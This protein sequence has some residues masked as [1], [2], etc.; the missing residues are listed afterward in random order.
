MGGCGARPSRGEDQRQT[1][2]R[3]HQGSGAWGRPPAT[4]PDCTGGGSQALRPGA[5]V[6]TA[7]NGSPSR[8]PRGKGRPPGPPGLQRATHLP[9]GSNPARESPRLHPSLRAHH[10][11]LNTS[12]D[13]TLTPAPGSPSPLHMGTTLLIPTAP[14]ANRAQGFRPQCCCLPV[15]LPWVKEP[16]QASL[17]SSIKWTLL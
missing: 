6:G 9:P 7:D 4:H 3:L 17:F 2:H 16:F 8:L 12:A 10:G 14:C 5:R 11:F 15:T 1:A 13:Q